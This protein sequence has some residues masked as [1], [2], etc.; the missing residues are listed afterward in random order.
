MGQPRRSG[1]GHNVHMTLFSRNECSEISFAITDYESATETDFV[2]RVRV[3]LIPN[4]RQSAPK[5][6]I[7]VNET[8]GRDRPP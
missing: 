2:N 4:L 3:S 5:A 6:E 1:S 8:A 7:A